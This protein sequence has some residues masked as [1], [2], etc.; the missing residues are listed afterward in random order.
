M[1]FKGSLKGKMLSAVVF[2]SIIMTI[3]VTVVG[4]SAVSRALV[5][6]G[7]DSMAQIAE[8]VLG[9][10]DDAY[11]GDFNIEIDMDQGT[12]KV[13]KGDT[14]ITS[15]HEIVD[16][17]ADSMGVEISIFCQS[18]RVETSLASANGDRY[19]TTKANP[20]VVSQVLDGGKAHFYEDVDLWG[21]RCY[22]YYAP[23][24]MSDGTVY[25]MVGVAKSKASMN[26]LIKAQVWK[27][28]LATIIAG[29]LFAIVAISF[30]NT[31]TKRISELEK[32][33]KAVAS[34]N[35]KADI[36]ARYSKGDDEISSLIKNTKDM[37]SSI[38]QLVDFDALTQLYNRR[39]GDKRCVESMERCINSNQP[40]CIA[41]GDIDFFKKVNDT[42]GHE[43]GDEIL[44]NV[45]KTLK[46][47]MPAGAFVARW[48]G[49]EFF[50]MFE[51]HTLE[52]AEAVLNAVLGN[53]R[54]MTT[55][56][57]GQEIKVTMSFG[58][59]LGIPG[60]TKD[61]ALKRADGNLYYAKENGRNQVR[62]V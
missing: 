48:G 59:T 55:V 20:M 38:R 11:P 21:E 30:I 3:V 7:R 24:M 5:S 17:L 40:Y 16:R 62:A 1:K 45:A 43:A 47:G 41:I 49:E 32:F 10:Y 31:I 57:E 33:T 27:V 15:K 22:V 12:Y 26:E 18:I 39:C 37:T 6:Q 8:A 46:L 56:F 19:I 35:F 42:Y 28:P 58:V 53:I 14:D 13:I 54:A 29:V 2:P 51:R 23:I 4:I 50:M 9:S 44:R 36:S 52:E 25:G 60:E 61:E 34:G